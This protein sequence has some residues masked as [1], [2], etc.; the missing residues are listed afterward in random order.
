MKI[1]L[2]HAPTEQGVRKVVESYNEWDLLEEVIVGVIEG[3]TVPEWTKEVKASMPSNMEQFYVEN[4]GKHFP[5]DEI[6]AAAKE[7][8]GFVALLEREGVVV[9]RPDRLD[10]KRPYSTPEWSSKGGLYQAMPRDILLVIGDEIIESPMAWRSRYF[11]INAFKPL[12][13][14]YFRQGARWT[15]APKPE[16]KDDLYNDFYIE[17]A[18]KGH[19][20]YGI[21]EFEPTFDAADFARCGR[22][23]FAQRSN[24]TNDFGIKWLQRHIGQEYRVHTLEVTDSHPMHIDATFVPL[25]PGCIL[26]NRSRLRELPAMFDTWEVIEAPMPALPSHHRLYMSS[27]WLSANTLMLDEKRIVVESHEKEFISVLK[28]RGFEPIL[29]DFQNFNSFG[30]SFHCATCDVRRKGNLETYF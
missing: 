25:R 23:I 6:Q 8:E 24:V 21:S 1:E 3:A 28:R 20:E 14:E 16:L 5:A 12:L 17:T 26:V 18:L 7:L 29:C 22:D 19:K 11:E 10:L 13:K 27:N 2:E 9:K 15:A 30:G 4:G